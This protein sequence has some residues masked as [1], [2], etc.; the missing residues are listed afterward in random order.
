MLWVRTSP[1][2]PV[3]NFQ[4]F[5]RPSPRRVAHRQRETLASCA[6]RGDY[7]LNLPAEDRYLHSQSQ[8]EADLATTLGDYVAEKLIFTE[9]T[10]GAADDLNKASELAHRLV[11]RYGMNKKY[12]TNG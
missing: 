5:C 2:P 4:K 10:T 1:Q 12:W 7:T 3:L 9:L 11:T 6:V 8:F